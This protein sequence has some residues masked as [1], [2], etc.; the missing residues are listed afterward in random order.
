MQSLQVLKK[1]NFAFLKISPYLLND[2]HIL[3]HMLY[4]VIVYI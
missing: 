4:T 3:N 1:I 2:P